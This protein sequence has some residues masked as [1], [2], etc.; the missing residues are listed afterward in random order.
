MNTGLGFPY[1]LCGPSTHPVAGARLDD[2]RHATGQ[3]P[4]SCCPAPL[5]TCSI[6][7]RPAPAPPSLPA[8]GDMT[9]IT[10]PTAFA[11]VPDDPSSPHYS[12]AGGMTI[13][14]LT[15]FFLGILAT[16]AEPA[17]NVLGETVETLS[18]GKFTKKML[19]WA[20][21]VGVAIGMCA[22]VF[23]VG[24]EAAAQPWW[25]RPPGLPP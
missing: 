23:G 4:L 8:L 20:V 22:G 25:C 19:I 12:F 24:G 10:L 18:G 3:P 5:P 15:I 21:C 17:L 9:G 16:K 13:C 1:C 6:R 2:G 7:T 11:K 14:M